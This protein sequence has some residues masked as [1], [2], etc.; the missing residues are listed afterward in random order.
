MTQGDALPSLI[1]CVALSYLLTI[2]NQ[3]TLPTK[4]KCG[5]KFNPL[6]YMDD[7]KLHVKTE[8][9]QMALIYTANIF[10]MDIGI[11][12]GVIKCAKVII[13]SEHFVTRIDPAEGISTGTG[14]IIDA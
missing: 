3:T 5:Q 13:H 1:F 6:L 2:L 7:L 11:K 8:N 14:R 10:R 9:E 4:L 12:F